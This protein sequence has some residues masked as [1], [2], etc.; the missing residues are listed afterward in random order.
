MIS[1]DPKRA[2]IIVAG[3]LVL[4]EMM[5][6]IRLDYLFVSRRGLATD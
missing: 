6:E 4:H 5:A 3:G 1:G 2:D